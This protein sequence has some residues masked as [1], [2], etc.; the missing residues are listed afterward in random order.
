MDALPQLSIEDTAAYLADAIRLHA[1]LEA[2]SAEGENEN[3][4]LP[5]GILTCSEACRMVSAV[6]ALALQAYPSLNDRD[7]LAASIQAFIAGGASGA[8]N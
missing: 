6:V 5:R 1:T 3:E 4:P 2:I 7:V 8:I